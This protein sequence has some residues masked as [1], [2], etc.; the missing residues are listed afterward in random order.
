MFQI[1]NIQYILYFSLS[2]IKTKNTFSS[3]PCGSITSKCY[4]YFIFLLQS[5]KLGLVP[6]HVTW[7]S[8]I[9]I[10]LVSFILGMTCNLCKHRFLLLLLLFLFPHFCEIF[11]FGLE[12]IYS[13]SSLPSFF[14][15]GQLAT[16]WLAF[17]QLK[18]SKGS[19]PLYF[20]DHFLSLLTK[21]DSF[22]SNSLLELSLD[23]CYMFFV[24][25]EDLNVAYFLDGFFVHF[26][27]FI[28]YVDPM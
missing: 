12:M 16:K 4:T 14:A 25:F 19:L 8:I 27:N 15:Y 2:I 9:N 5:E 18:H 1:I 28:C 3:Y 26:P 21:W 22:A 17:P 11:I 23:L 10:P 13:S 7:T 24:F 6:Y 20:M